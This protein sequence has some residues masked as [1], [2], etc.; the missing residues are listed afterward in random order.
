MAEQEGKRE[1]V[2]TSEFL[3]LKAIFE[4]VNLGCISTLQLGECQAFQ[5]NLEI[6]RETGLPS[7]IR[8]TPLIHPSLT[9][10]PPVSAPIITNHIKKRD[11]NKP[12]FNSKNHNKIIRI[13]KTFPLIRTLLNIHQLTNQDIFPYITKST[14]I[15]FQT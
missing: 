4:E 9:E 6:P 3:K 11:N 10:Q 15:D 12:A 13:K 1:R 5:P 7:K 8:L 14:G 2:I